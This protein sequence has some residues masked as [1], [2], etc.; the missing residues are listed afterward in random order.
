MALAYLLAVLAE[1]VPGAVLVTALSPPAGRTGAG[2]AH[3]VTPG[4]VMAGTGEGTGGAPPSWR[5]GDRAGPP[6]EP[7]GAL[8][9]PGSDTLPVLT[10]GPEEYKN[11]MML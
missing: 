3:G 2:A 8:T 5:T 1:G 6:S 9:L 11:P 7:S 10:P 4:S